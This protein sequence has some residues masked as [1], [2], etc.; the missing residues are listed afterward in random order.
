MHFNIRSLIAFIFSL[1]TVLSISAS[2]SVSYIP[3]FHGT[4][5]PRMEVSMG[6]TPT[7]YRF[8]LRNARV[9][10]NGF[11]APS[12]D[13]FLQA[14]LCDRGSMKF[15]DGWIRLT[16]PNGF[17]VQAGQ[18]RMPFAVDPFRAPHTY[19][20]SNRSFIGKQIFNYRAVGLKFGYQIPRVPLNIEAGIFNPSKITDHTPWNRSM[21]FS[22][23]ATCRLKDWYVSAGFASISPDSVRLNAIDA[24]VTWEHGRW[25]AESEYMVTHYAHNRFKRNQAFNAFTSYRIPIKLG[26]FN[27]ISFQG[28]FDFITDHS[29]GWRFQ[30]K[31]LTINNPARRRITAGTTL[32]YIRSKSSFLDIRADFEKYFY[33]DVA[34]TPEMDSKLV[35]EM[36]LRF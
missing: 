6:N 4:L 5:R 35:L 8:Q 9:S 30:N 14:D 11:I 12:V 25:I 19:I 7:S 16:I 33:K 31:L 3:E 26:L 17:K 20:F 27:R 15:L 24:A 18:F 36:I 13:Y 34:P 1:I 32:S 21:A 23:K 10:A 29:T 22:A 28:R 2:D